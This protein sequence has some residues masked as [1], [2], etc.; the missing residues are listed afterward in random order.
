MKK[1]AQANKDDVIK[2]LKKLW[3][4]FITHHTPS[5]KFFLNACLKDDEVQN[6][7]PPPEVLRILAVRNGGDIGSLTDVCML[8]SL[9]LLN[10][11]LLSYSQSDYPKIRVMFTTDECETIEEFEV[12]N[13]LRKPLWLHDD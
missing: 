12:K 2:D 10:G 5:K 7:E 1:I 6:I 3:G 13:P 4:L 9:E 11:K 8:E